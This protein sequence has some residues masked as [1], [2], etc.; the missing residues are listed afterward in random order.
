MLMCLLVVFPTA[1]RAQLEESRYVS[2]RGNSLSDEAFYLVALSEV[3]PDKIIRRTTRGAI[4]KGKEARHLKTALPVNDRWK[5]P[6]HY[7]PRPDERGQYYVKL[8]DGEPGIPDE[9]GSL[10]IASTADSTVWLVTGGWEDIE[11]RLLPD[12]N[13]VFIQPAHR[14]PQE[15][16]R[17]RQH[18]LSA[19]AIRLVHHAYPELRGRGL[20]VSVKENAF[21]PQ[22]IDLAGR[23]VVDEQASPQQETHA[24]QM[25]TLIGG[26]G[27]TATS[28]RGVADQATLYS[29]D[30][31]SLLPEPNRYY[32]S[33]NITVQ[34]H[35]YGTQ[36]ENFYGVESA[37]YDALT[38]E[39]RH[40]LHV[41]SVGNQGAQAGTGRYEG[42]ASYGTLTG[43]F[44]QA[45]NVLLVSSTD[46][47]GRVSERNS[48]GPAYDGRV[49]P[50][51][52]A[53]GGEGTSEAAA[54]VSGSSLLIQE[55]YR[56]LEGT[57]PTSAM[58]RALLIAGSDDLREEGPDFVSG[59]GQLNLF[60]SLELLDRGG[61][62]S[63]QVSSGEAQRWELTVPPGTAHVVCVLTWND[64]PAH[65][66]DEV[67]LVNDLDLTIRGD[68]Q[69]FLPWILDAAPA[70]ASLSRPATTGIDRLNTVEMITLKD[71]SAGVY[72]VT[73]EGTSVAERQSYSL[74]YSMT[75]RDAFRWT[76]P[77]GSDP[78]VAQRPETVRW[79]TPLA[80]S[81]TLEIDYLR[82][83][84][85][86]LAAVSLA[87]GRQE[88]L[89]PDTTALARLR[90]VTHQGIYVSDTF[91][92]SPSA[93][94]AVDLNC[95]DDLMLT[96]NAVKGATYS[97]K[98]Y[99]DEELTE[100]VTTA[101]TFLLLKKTA[102]PVH[103]FSV[104]PTVEDRASRPSLLVDTQ[105]Q[106]VGCYIN[107]FLAVQNQNDAVDLRVDLAGVSLIREVQILKKVRGGPPEVFRAFRPTTDQYAIEDTDR[108]VG[109][110][111]YQLSV[112]LKEGEPVVSQ[113]IPVFYTDDKTYLNFPNPVVGDFFHFL[114]PETNATLQLLDWQGRIVK[115]LEL[116]NEHEEVFVGD[117]PPSVYFFRVTKGS[118]FLA[119]GKMIIQ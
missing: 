55:Q 32:Q 116:I 91:L 117:L 15:E 113:E 66:G 7:Q 90:M 45:K 29:T 79:N 96:W 102:E 25:A 112:L 72:T 100:V 54:L 92:I 50:D 44:K 60:R 31:S 73:V 81:G 40:L 42:I 82:A 23:T 57:E 27:Y 41:F 9:V 2:G 21:D 87:N 75:A 20:T 105:Q 53:F 103:L 89:F 17:L 4:V 3:S 30:F 86:P 67:A 114:S 26:A 110:T 39:N 119:S 77:S 71:P 111:S 80:G 19:N 56:A 74:A 99:R 58:V 51:L 49:K 62:R 97:V 70:E 118:N 28:G 69:T 93:T 46:S 10:S 101:D 107:N 47:L 37:A 18:D 108:E 48:R 94:L 43:S 84:W 64:P 88:I 83:Q 24:T 35:S 5:L 78:V 6:G 11:Q 12:Q 38:Q 61:Y 76:F 106:G 13:V 104:H 33:R 115:E 109:V 8:H 98:Q 34:N 1:V 22:D 14:K 68:E 85:Q 52:V 65:E 95:T 36:V 16:T 63:G 59:Y